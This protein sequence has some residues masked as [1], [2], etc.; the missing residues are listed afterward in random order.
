MDSIKVKNI[1]NSIKHITYIGDQSQNIVKVIQIDKD[2]NDPSIL[3]WCSDK[4]KDLLLDIK[5]GTIIISNNI[6]KD[7]LNSD[8]NYIVVENPR[9]TFQEILIRFFVEKTQAEISKT[10]AIHTSTSI[11][12]NVFIGNNTIIEKNCKI[13]NNVTIQHNTVIFKDTIIG[14]NVTIGANNTIGGIGF[15]YEKDE[16]GDFQL[17]PHIGNVVL[18]DNVEIGNNTTIDRA[19]LGSTIL[20]ENVKVDN[21]VHIAHGVK[22]GRNSVII[23]NSMIAGSVVIGEN[24]WIAPSSSVLNQKSI[25]NNSLVGMGAVVLKNVGDNEVVAGSPAKL[26]KKI[27]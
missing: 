15:G 25:G 11:G 17:I 9:R 2:N 13:G 10:S 26:L 16:N 6:I 4:N 22:I 18:K 20:E 3:S 1:L 21:L 23:A 14:N 12:K 24:T 8:C 19:V 5:A 7:N 27:K